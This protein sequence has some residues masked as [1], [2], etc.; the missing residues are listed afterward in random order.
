[1]AN[2]I[3]SPSRRTVLLGAGAALAAPSIVR[4]QARTLA[5]SDPGGVYTTAYT[6]AYYKPFT[7]ETG[8]AITPVV[9]RSNPAAE[10][11]AQ[12]DTRN[13]NWDISGGITSDV[14][15]LLAEQKLLE[16]VDLSGEASSAIPAEMKNGFYM[17]DSVVTF[18]LAY[19]R[20]KFAGGP[21]SFADIWDVSKFPGRRAMRKLA[22]DMIEIALRADGVPGGPDVYKV[23]AAPGGWDRAFRKLD[24]IRPSVQVWWDSSPQS[25]QLLQS[26]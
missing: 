5:V 4:A 9:R 10:F 19:R 24:A 26:G 15:D 3:M 23:L 11:K 17:A 14:A 22:R 1:M 16:P 12:V 8:I 6:E 21:G 20:D 13:F 7:Q 18:V 2:P 25:T